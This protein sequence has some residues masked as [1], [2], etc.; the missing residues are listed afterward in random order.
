[1]SLT[2]GGVPSI[3]PVCLP[4]CL[5]C[6]RRPVACQVLRADTFLTRSSV[7]PQIIT[8]LDGEPRIPPGLPD[9]TNLNP[10]RV[11]MHSRTGGLSV[12]LCLARGAHH[13]TRQL[14]SPAHSA[15]CSSLHRQLCGSQPDDWRHPAHHIRRCLG[16][17]FPGM[18][19]QHN[20]LHHDQCA[21]HVRFLQTF[22][23]VSSSGRGFSTE[24]EIFRTPALLPGA[25]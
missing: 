23:L 21:Q 16:R 6:R 5:S 17:R 13:A 11:G 10:V 25:Q 4:V 19:R 1:M 7:P 3:A 22:C 12:R 15:T 9:E 18:G 24:T 20:H 14:A 8:P 2:A